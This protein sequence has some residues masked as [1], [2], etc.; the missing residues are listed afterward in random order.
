MNK[1]KESGH[2]MTFHDK[3]CTGKFQDSEI[4][5][6]DIWRILVQ[7]RKWIVTITSIATLVASIYAFVS[8]SVYKA[9]VFISPPLEADIIGLNL[10][11]PIREEI[12]NDITVEKIFQKTTQNLKSSILQQKYYE[13]HKGTMGTL[14]VHKISGGIIVSIE[15]KHPEGLAKVV[16]DFVAFIDNYTVKYFTELIKEKLTVKK[17]EIQL[18]I[19]SLRNQEKQQLLDRIA[20]LTEALWIAK[21]LKITDIFI[22]PKD[23][24]LYLRGSKAL[25]AEI[26]ALTKRKNHDAFIFGLRSLQ[27]KYFKLTQVKFDKPL[28]RGLQIDRPAMLPHNPVKSKRKVIVILGA[29][30]GL[31]SGIFVAFLINYFGTIKRENIVRENT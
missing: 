18:K 22:T 10:L 4:D 24:P 20:V 17:A 21:K 2:Q 6:V 13:N 30:I 9:E 1:E 7:H 11:S 16:N 26:E 28:V 25:T 12:I 15:G 14:S 31:M 8:P 23:S 3:C 19:K 27:K 5:L 29:I